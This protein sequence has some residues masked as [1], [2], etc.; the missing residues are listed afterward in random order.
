MISTNIIPNEISELQILVKNLLLR[1]QQLEEIV[2]YLKGERFASS[3]EKISD[4]QLPLFTLSPEEEFVSKPKTEEKIESYTRKKSGRKKLPENIERI[5]IEHDLTPEEKQCSCGCGEKE[6]IGE[7]ISEQLDIIPASF[8]I[9]QHVR[10]KYACKKCAEGVSIAKLPEQIIPKSN[11]TPNLLAHIAISKY[12]DALPLYRQTVI[13]KR[14][15]TD[16]SRAT[17]TNW[18]LEIGEKL[19]P[20]VNLMLEHTLESSYIGVDETRIQVLKEADRKAQ[21][22]SYMWVIK[23]GPPDKNATIFY[24]DPHRS[25]KVLKEIIADYTGYLQS[26]AFSAYIGLDTMHNIRIVGCFAHA[27][28]YFYKAFKNSENKEGVAFAGLEFIRKL[29]KIEKDIANKTPEKRFEIRNIEAKPILLE[30]KNW[31]DNIIIKVPP[32]TLTGEALHYLNS[33]WQYLIRY[34]EEGFLEIDNNRVENA[35]RP[36]VVGRKNWLF[37]DSPKGALAS[38]NIYTLIETAK[39]NELDPFQ[40]LKTVFNKLPNT[41]NL[42]D[43]ENLLPWNL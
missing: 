34:L 12:Q 25:Q 33:K 38:A 40:Y 31:L 24:Y 14:Y 42:Q 7:E 11:A 23:G 30:M 39:N 20:L 10:F 28:R 19:Q 6:K 18:M 4:D 43:Y 26:D 32:K 3:S 1:N 22:Q 8:R 37:C 2:R 29:Y 17:L 16:I 13:F 27:R 36:F 15:G 41:K 9:L 35:I 5:R 21:T